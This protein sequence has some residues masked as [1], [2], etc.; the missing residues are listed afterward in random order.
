[1]LAH[2][3]FGLGGTSR[4]GQMLI[5]LHGVE[6][7][8]SLRQQCACLCACATEISPMRKIF[9]GEATRLSANEF[10]SVGTP[11]VVDRRSQYDISHFSC[12]SLEFSS[13]RL[14]RP[15]PLAAL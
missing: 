13:F 10:N 7:Q 14:Q 8:V 11:A 9:S 4:A 15:R 3:L 2:S 5:V 1:M 6:F 12:S